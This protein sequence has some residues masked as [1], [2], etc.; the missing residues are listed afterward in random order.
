MA[1]ASFERLLERCLQELAHTGD[2]EASLRCYPQ[3][4]DRLRPLL[5][6]AQATR[7]YYDAV[8]EAPGGLEA[9]RERLLVAAAQQRVSGIGATPVPT[10][11]AGRTAG[12]KMKFAFAPRLIAVL[13]AVVVG[14]AAFGGGV[15]WAADN[16][17]PGDLFYPVKLAIEDVRLALASAPKDQIDLALQFVEERAEEIQALVGVSHQV[18]DE[19][20]TRMERHVER[21]LA[22][23]AWASDEETAGLLMQIA[24][25]TRTQEQ[26]L[27]QIQ[28]TAPQQARPG[29]G[30][31]AAVCRWG[32]EAAEAGLIDPQAFRW[33]YRHQHGTPAPANEPQQLTVTPGDDQ[34]QEPTSVSTPRATPQG[35]QATFV[36]QPTPQGPQ[37]TFVPQPTPQ[38]PR[39]TF[40]PQPT[41][42]GPQATSMPQ[43]TPKGPRATFVPQPTPQG[44]QATFVP[45]PTPQGPRATPVPQ[46]TP[47]G[48]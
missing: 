17:L 16:S 30:R 31:A 40:A 46:A 47:R 43:P 26:R 28:A 8:P 15:V 27:E 23:T 19:A 13:L 10:D 12:R 3:Y 20:V 7:R 14:A 25:R 9:G 21:A 34:E 29:L 32:A 39:A 5:E 11:R 22:R 4:A 44:P 38:G 45:Q 1:H 37:A 6:M 2:V 42:Q 33:R 35:P 48:P 18:P 24:K 36:P 41:P